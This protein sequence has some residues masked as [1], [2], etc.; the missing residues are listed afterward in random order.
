MS[1]QPL[2][3]LRTL[4][5]LAA[6]LPGL[7]GALCTPGSD[8]T[9]LHFN[10]YHGQLEPY[11]DAGHLEPARSPVSQNAPQPA[12]TGT[13][14]ERG[15]IARLAATVAQVRAERPGRPVLLLFG[16]D[17]LQGTVTSSLFLGIP[18]VTLFG[19]MGVNAAVMGNHEL[20]YG[21][22]VFRRLAG[23][24]AFPFLSANVE[25][26]PEPLPVR[27][28]VVLE[29]GEGLRV[30]VLGLTTPEL[31]TATHPRNAVGLAV[32]EP[33]TVA[34]RLLPD[35][36]QGTD[37]TVVLSH[38]GITDDR[39]LARD[40]PGID[41]IV[42]GHN[43]NLYTQPEMEGKTAIVQAGERGGWL[44]RMD[45]TCTDG[46]LVQ[47]GYRMIEITPASPEDPEMAAEVRRIDAEADGHLDQQIGTAARELSAWREVMRRGEAPLADFVADLAR[48]YTRAEVALFN[49]GNFRASI[50]AGP[51]T[52]KSIYETFPFRN[53][54]VVG[55]LTVAQLLAA[56]GRSAALDPLD[57][58]GGF[59]QVSG[60]RYVIENGRLAS[61]TIGGAPIES[62]RRYRVVVPD[63]LAAG[64][65]GYDMLKS[66]D[67]VDQ[68]GR[69]VSDM[70]IEG[71]R[72]AGTVDPR[73]DGRI[74][75][76]SP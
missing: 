55:D 46:R 54:L 40:V 14:M 20:D 32:E 8:L 61:A 22:D 21:Q 5:L 44:G 24:A 71:I 51:I 7:A 12:A 39:R 27:P 47:T 72:D 35:L 16:G 73:P 28:G 30:A 52:L 2:A 57:N 38:L 15:G 25:S 65:D 37:L 63:F 53:E 64:G 58:P 75:R 60:L 76:R 13:K 59:L 34:R 45:F 48:N 9:L 11:T 49:G 68:T 31:T 70:V 6:L 18:D 23:Q 50:P 66:M 42:G 19:R 74:E 36:S 62:E 56:L 69:L 4:P 10:D 67:N 3:P 41:L 29:P 1:F 26:H 33:V 43:H 17:L